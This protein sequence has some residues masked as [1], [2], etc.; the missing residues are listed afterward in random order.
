MVIELK[1]DVYPVFLLVVLVINEGNFQ[2][3]A[4]LLEEAAQ[5]FL[6]G[7]GQVHPLQFT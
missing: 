4:V 2:R 3:P 6:D 5:Q 1:A 7:F